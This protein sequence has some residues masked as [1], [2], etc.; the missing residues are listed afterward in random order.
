MGNRRFNRDALLEVIAENDPDGIAEFFC[1]LLDRV[2]F[3]EAP[4]GSQ[5]EIPPEGSALRSSVSNTELLDMWPGWAGKTLAVMDLFDPDR[6]PEKYLLHLARQCGVNVS[7]FHNEPAIDNRAIRQLIKDS[8][9]F[10]RDR[11]SVV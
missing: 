3:G 2:Y 6:C 10:A 8:V 7:L 9:P 4:E 1:N 5:V 11:K